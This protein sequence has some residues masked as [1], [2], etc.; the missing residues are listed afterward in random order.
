MMTQNEP[1]HVLVIGAG[2]AGAA[3]A[4]RL[5]EAGLS[6][7]CLE[8]G[9][10]GRRQLSAGRRDDRQSA[11]PG[12]WRHDPNVRRHPEDYPIE[13]SQSPIA[14]LMHTGVGGATAHWSGLS[15]RFH[16]SDFLAK[17]LD[18]AGRDWPLTYAELEPYYD[19]NDRMM[20]CT[21]VAGDPANPLRRQEQSPPAPLG[22]DV[23]LLAR[24]FD[25]LGWH[26]WPASI[27][28]SNP[29]HREGSGEDDSRRTSS[30]GRVPHPGAGV[31][32][33]YWP[34]AT[35]NGAKLRTRC[36]AVEITIDDDGRA[37]GA[38]YRDRDGRCHHQ[39]AR[40]VAV[41]CNGIGT[42]RLLLASRSD[43]HPQG[44]ANSTG[45]VGK[46]LML[47]P[48]AVVVGLFD[49][50]IQ[51][52]AHRPGGALVSQEFYETD[53]RRAFVRGY[54]LRTTRT[55]GPLD[56]VLGPAAEAVPWGGEHHPEFKRRCG[57]AMALR[58]IAEDLPELHNDV[59][60]DGDL[61]DSSG[62]PA[63]KL[64]YTVSRNSRML[65]DHG[66]RNARRVLETAGAQTVLV[67]SLLRDDGR[68]LMG[69]ARMGDDPEDSVLNP[70]GQ[71]WD[72]DNLFVIDGSVFV[73]SAAVS[74]TATIQALALRTADH[75][76]QERTD[77]RA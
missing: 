46:N 40:A 18:G 14:P 57:R 34:L 45:L 50:D 47:H 55:S 41:A 5:S 62:V 19:L 77:L 17:T 16:P 7:V 58:V 42:P 59:T 21:G 73:T 74:P 31:D 70:W 43:R 54:A 27:F 33:T 67:N 25:R 32:A 51:S 64:R 22:P 8:Q 23:L 36:R 30:N 12:R 39:P 11:E 15:E 53:P 10:W 26:W 9:G 4:W 1:A 2:A 60:L 28:G 72:V 13:S 76:V 24:A 71:A 48:S 63:P 56:A 75:I 66:I 29:S 65:L 49:R 68:H 37:S 38:T 20:G 3:L 44:L 52:G 35:R 61:T 6:V 69:A